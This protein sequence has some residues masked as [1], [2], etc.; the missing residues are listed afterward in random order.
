M[1]KKKHFLGRLTEKTLNFPKSPR[2]FSFNCSKPS[3]YV[4]ISLKLFVPGNVMMLKLLQIAPWMTVLL[5]LT[6]NNYTNWWP[7]EKI[8]FES[9][10]FFK[11]LF[12]LQ[13]WFHLFTQITSFV[14]L[15]DEPCNTWII[16][17]C[18]FCLHT[19]CYVIP[20]RNRSCV[21]VSLWWQFPLGYCACFSN[22]F[23]SI[24]QIMAGG[25]QHHID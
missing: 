2:Y 24:I 25:R 21:G 16:S 14:L 3:D 15:I 23:K 20:Q 17:F 11:H 19:L 10:H 18:Y 5:I 13:W 4:T 7:I 1:A 12:T 9:L 6:R 22:A 8:W